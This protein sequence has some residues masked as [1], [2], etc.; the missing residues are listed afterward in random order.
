MSRRS[1][2]A[3]RPPGE[4]HAPSR[5]LS[6]PQAP[7]PLSIVRFGCA[8]IAD[9]EPQALGFTYWFDAA[10]D[11][12]PYALTLQFSGRRIDVKGKRGPSDSFSVLETIDPVLPGSGRIA[13]TTRL[14]DVAAGE[15]EVTVTP[16]SPP[17]ARGRQVAP[18]ARRA[19][20]RSAGGSATGPTGFA[21]IIRVR[22]PGARLA[23]WPALVSLGVVIAL[24]VQ[25]LLAAH[26][27]LIESRIIVISLVAC[28]IG[29]VGA[30]VYYLAIYRGEPLLTSGMCIQGFIIA[31]IGSLIVGATL[32]GVA[33][34]R[35]LDITA[36]GLLLGT[37]I[38]RFGCFF[39]GCCAGRPSTS[40]WAP[41]SS[42]RTLGTRRIPTQ[43][44]ESA[45]A[46]TLGTAT[47][48]VTWLTSPHP[49][50]VVFV[51]AIAAYTLGRQLLFPLR[52]LPRKTTRGRT[53]TMLAA[54]LVLVAD[55][56]VTALS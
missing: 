55:L 49:T 50:G 37:M 53:L 34:G 24:V 35:L 9:V 13:V 45:L 15:W 41:W 28:L 3:A 29:L 52:S 2:S 30:K 27:G 44:L 42:D 7:G 5:P 40:R 26:T 11:G 8:A 19:R 20:P 4:K 32:A 18:A 36:P 16:V 46:G 21:P 17:R 22:A 23:A 54:G 47:L 38:G 43:L 31:A 48:L 6:P 10:P 14:Y 33:V 39:G 25:A 12:E 51:A 1:A 56:A